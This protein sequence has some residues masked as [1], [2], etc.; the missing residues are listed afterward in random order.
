[1]NTVIRLANVILGRLSHCSKA[2]TALPRPP[3]TESEEILY[4]YARPERGILCAFTTHAV[5]FRKSSTEW[6]AFPYRELSRVVT[7]KNEGGRE[8][9]LETSDGRSVRPGLDS[10]NTNNDVFEILRFLMRVI[11]RRPPAR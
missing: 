5:H 3:A 8:L 6:I 9:V 2:N 11:H 7:E 1:M 10:S 4:Y